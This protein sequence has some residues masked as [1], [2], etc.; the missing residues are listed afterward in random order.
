MYKSEY[1]S[2]SIVHFKWV[3]YTVCEL[4]VNKTGNKKEGVCVC[5]HLILSLS[6]SLASS[7]A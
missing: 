7:H 1:T 2:R 6:T 3:N 4:E 5:F